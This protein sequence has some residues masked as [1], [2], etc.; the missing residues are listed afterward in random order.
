M[1]RSGQV[2]LLVLTVAVLWGLSGSVLFTERSPRV[3]VGVG[4]TPGED[5]W[6]E[7]ATRVAGERMEE[8][9]LEMTAWADEQEQ[10]YSEEG[11]PIPFDAS[12]FFKWKYKE[13]LAMDD[14]NIPRGAMIPGNGMVIPRRIREPIATY[15]WRPVPI[16]STA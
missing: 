1:R 9:Y 13:L 2:V 4:T 7:R 15:T 11:E 12:I 6:V 8:W 3:E 14:P 10:V 16:P 5:P